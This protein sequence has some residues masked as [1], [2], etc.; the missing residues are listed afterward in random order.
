[1]HSEQNAREGRGSYTLTGKTVSESSEANQHLDTEHMPLCLGPPVQA[2]PAGIPM[3]HAHA[4]INTT[5]TLT[6]PHTSVICF[7]LHNS[8]WCGRLNTLYGFLERTAGS[9]E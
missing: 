6:N 5:H 1:M 7:C 4:P 9:R 3:I 2:M 8:T